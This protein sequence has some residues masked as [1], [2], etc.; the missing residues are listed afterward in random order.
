MADNGKI[1]PTTYQQGREISALQ[2]AVE[3]QGESLGRSLD[4][5][6]ED[7]K[8]LKES[9]ATKTDVAQTTINCVRCAELCGRIADVER[10]LYGKDKTGKESGRPGLVA[11]VA[12]NKTFIIGMTAVIGAAAFFAAYLMPHV[13]KLIGIN[14]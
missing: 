11:D 6:R 3:K 5:I 12:A 14:A 4:L 1:D 13:L 7:L 10:D 2:T 8:G 9:M